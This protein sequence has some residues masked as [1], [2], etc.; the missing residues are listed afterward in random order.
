MHA[1]P[2]QASVPARGTIPDHPKL[3]R[4]HP[5]VCTNHPP[6]SMAG[7]V[8]LDDARNI[9]GLYSARKTMCKLRVYPEGRPRVDEVR[10]RRDAGRIP[11]YPP[12]MA[13]PGT[14]GAPMPRCICGPRMPWME[15][16]ARTLETGSERV[17]Q[18]T[19]ATAGHRDT[20]AACPRDPW[21][22]T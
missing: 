6:A 7:S 11:G 4:S 8:Q 18:P 13:S 22:R 10:N 2:C 17:L 19:R 5:G 21:S 1:T 16:P 15:P 3:H 14:P 20:G 12:T 9:Y